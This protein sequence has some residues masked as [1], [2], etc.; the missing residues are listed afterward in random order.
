LEAPNPQRAIATAVSEAR[1]ILSE[2]NACSD[3]LCGVGRASSNSYAVRALDA[4]GAM[5]K[6]GSCK[7]TEAGIC[8]TPPWHY[9]GDDSNFRVLTYRIPKTAEVNVAGPF[10]NSSYPHNLSMSLPQIG[11]YAPNTEWAR[12][13]Q[14]LHEVGHMVMDPTIAQPPPSNVPLLPNDGDSDDRS[15]ENTK[16]VQRHCRQQIEE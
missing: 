3:F 7:K 9:E 8:L 14:I 2:Q 12:V 6:V 11:T 1:L 5:L 16:I 4:L 15:I 13:L 10:L